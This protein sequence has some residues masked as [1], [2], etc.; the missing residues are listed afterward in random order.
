MSVVAF[1]AS[2]VGLNIVSENAEEG[3]L[4]CGFGYYWSIRILEDGDVI[5]YTDWI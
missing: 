4:H 3:F 5:G 2:F 1:C